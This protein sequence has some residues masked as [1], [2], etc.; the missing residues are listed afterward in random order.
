[1][2]KRKQPNVFERLQSASKTRTVG[3]VKI[4]GWLEDPDEAILVYIRRFPFGAVEFFQKLKKGDNISGETLTRMRK[5]LSDVARNEDGS[6][7]FTYE[8][9]G[10]LGYDIVLDFC[11]KIVEGASKE[12]KDSQP[13]QSS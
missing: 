10:E 7:M 3:K 4:K 6:P 1:M 12:G 8:Q 11:T 5:F 13:T 2:P 9:V